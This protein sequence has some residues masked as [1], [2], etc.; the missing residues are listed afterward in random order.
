MATKAEL[1]QEVVRLRRKIQEGELE[2]D[3]ESFKF[4][5]TFFHLQFCTLV[6]DEECSYYLEESMENTW[7]Q[8]E[9][10]KWT[11]VV[12]KLL[13]ACQ[14]D[15]ENEEDREHIGKTCQ[16]Y[17]RFASSTLKQQMLLQWM[18]DPNLEV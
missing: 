2:E 9:H 11:G 5:I 13:E 18:L 8:P 4:L 12:I 3:L 6:H 14:L 17:K 1:E 10:L 7:A 15:V 16:L